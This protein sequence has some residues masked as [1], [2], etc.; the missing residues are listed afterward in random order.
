LQSIFVSRGHG[1]G[2]YELRCKNCYSW[3]QAWQ[4]VGWVI[5]AIILFIVV[6]FFLGGL[7]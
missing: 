3:A 1:G 2:A 7:R 6:M 5:M 4:V